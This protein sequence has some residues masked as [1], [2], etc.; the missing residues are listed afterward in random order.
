MVRSGRYARRC[1]SRQACDRQHNVL[2]RPQLLALGMTD[3]MIEY[4]IECGLWRRPHLGVYAVAGAADRRLQALA[5]AC[6]A[7]WPD[8]VVSHTSAAALWQFES[9]SSEGIE[10]T[11]PYGRLPM[12]DG[13]RVHRTRRLTREDRTLF[14]NVPITTPIRTLID[15][16]GVLDADPFERAADD[17]HRRRMFTH[18]SLRRRVDELCGTGR[19]GSRMLKRLLVERD[20]AASLAG[21]SLE[22]RFH[23]LLRVAGIALP[24]SQYD[25]PGLIARVDF[26][27]PD[28]KVAIEIDGYRWHTGRAKFDADRRRRRK[29]RAARWDVLEFTWT[30]I[31]D[32]P[33]GVCGEV[34]RALAARRL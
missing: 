20:P 5:A 31:R 14:K 22:R 2:A 33:E 11:V 25:V 13:V 9:I 26:A 29:L 7:A 30:D 1:P 12:I 15:I 32:F 3:D 16:A 18:A 8:A 23:M 6:L 17:G 34:A 28:I 21:S 4:R 10:I 27:Y 24:V 19:A